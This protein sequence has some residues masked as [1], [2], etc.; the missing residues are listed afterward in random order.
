LIAPLTVAP[1]SLYQSLCREFPHSWDQL[2]PKHISDEWRKLQSEWV[3]VNNYQ[4]KQKTEINATSRIIA[5]GDASPQ[6][7]GCVL[8]L[9]NENKNSMELILSKT[10]ICPREETNMP[11]LELR[12]AALLLRYLNYISN[13][14]KITSTSYLFFDS[15]ISLQWIKADKPI[16]YGNA[17]AV[18]MEM[19]MYNNKEEWYYISSENN[20]ADLLTQATKAK[21]INRK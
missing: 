21:K 7:Y 11:Q 8:Y 2:I 18:K 10:K 19:K 14:L 5:F 1:R 3:Q 13:L 16:K 4:I 17:N 12:A 6:A 15:Q 9:Y 20:P